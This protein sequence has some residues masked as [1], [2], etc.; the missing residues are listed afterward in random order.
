MTMEI[1]S[2]FDHNFIEIIASI[3]DGFHRAKME[4]NN[5]VY[6]KN[7]N[8]AQLEYATISEIE[9]GEQLREEEKRLEQAIQLSKEELDGY[10][11]VS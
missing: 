4:Y 8:S 10:S 2:E 11:L 9:L 7:E 1:V 5:D 6:G 3:A